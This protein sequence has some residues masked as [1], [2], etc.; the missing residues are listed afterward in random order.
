MSG[1]GDR[2]RRGRVLSKPRDRQR[3]LGT[4]AR[5]TESEE[6]ARESEREMKIE[7]IKIDVARQIDI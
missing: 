3:S 4:M 6:R 5:R 1:K 2:R 7:K